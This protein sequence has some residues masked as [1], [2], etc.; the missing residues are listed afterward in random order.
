MKRLSKSEY[1]YRIKCVQEHHLNKQKQKLL[2]E[3]IYK[4]VLKG[5]NYRYAYN[6]WNLITVMISFE[7]AS[8][9]AKKN[10]ESFQK[11]IDAFNS[12]G[13]AV[14]T[15]SANNKYWCKRDS[16]GKDSYSY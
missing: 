10:T 2:D 9:E 4:S 12:L 1:Q 3:L 5:F 14:V 8:Q 6:H 16:N 13:N 15:N 11:M 7:L